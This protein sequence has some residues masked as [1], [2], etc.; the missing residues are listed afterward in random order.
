MDVPSPVFTKMPVGK[1]EGLE[2]TSQ[3]SSNV[4]HLERGLAGLCPMW[5]TG[6]IGQHIFFCCGPLVLCPMGVAVDHP[7]FVL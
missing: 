6:N 4:D 3:M 1:K 2:T 5:F 7:I